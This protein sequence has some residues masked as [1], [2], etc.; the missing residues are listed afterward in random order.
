MQTKPFNVVDYLETQEDIDGYLA[1]VM[2][3]GGS[4]KFIAHAIT[5]AE[6]ARANLQQTSMENKNLMEQ[7]QLFESLLY[8]LL[9]LGYTI[10][11]PVTI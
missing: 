10:K 4:A 3:S 1:E 8:R 2:Q 9:S 6:Q 7:P 11:P 5:Q